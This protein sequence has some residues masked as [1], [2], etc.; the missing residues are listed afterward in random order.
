M[1]PRHGRA[2]LTSA[3]VVGRLKRQLNGHETQKAMAK[4]IGC[5]VQFLNDVLRGR[6]EPSGKVLQYLS[7]E[8]VV[9]YK[10]VPRNWP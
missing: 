5:S 3:E 9:S 10:I 1:K 6:R 8:R 4:E 7:L 2:E